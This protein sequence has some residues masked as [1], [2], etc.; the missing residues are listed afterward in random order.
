MQNVTINRKAGSVRSTN[1]GDVILA[2]YSRQNSFKYALVVKIIT[3]SRVSRPVENVIKKI[4][5][6]GA[7]TRSKCIDLT[8]Q[9]LVKIC[10]VC[11]IIWEV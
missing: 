8:I 6:R 4:L 1:E 11:L 10:T 9:G 3:A 2:N 5:S 7:I